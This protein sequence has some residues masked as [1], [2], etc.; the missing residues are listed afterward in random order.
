MSDTVCTRNAACKC[1]DCSAYSGL[2]LKGIGGSAEDRMAD[3]ADAAAAPMPPKPTVGRPKSLAARTKAPAPPPAS[4]N[5]P[6]VMKKTP[7]LAMVAAPAE[8]EVDVAP[9][10]AVRSDSPPLAR[11][12]AASFAPADAR[13]DEE[14][15]GGDGPAPVQGATPPSHH[16]PERAPQMFPAPRPPPAD[17]RPLAERL[18][19]KV[20]YSFT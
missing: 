14:F 19:D 9:P 4:E 2:S 20:G 8:E 7:V 17:D 15:P 11:G 10:V 16:T 13:T 18:A 1:V 3:G 6:V 12:G 5:E